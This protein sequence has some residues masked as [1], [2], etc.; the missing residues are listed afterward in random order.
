MSDSVVRTS[1]PSESSS[2]PEPN[3]D[4]QDVSLAEE[5][6]LLATYQEKN[7]LPYT[8]EY[9][10][11]GDV[12]DRDKSLSDD[13][14]D[15]ESYLRDQVTK[16]ELKNSVDAGKKRLKELEKKADVDPVMD[17]ENTRIRKLTAYIDFLRTIS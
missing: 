1:A 14:K 6:S 9:F 7:G 3:A 16:E 5:K 12:W 15:I 13:L 10:E 17:T 11:L 8:A 4:R 2:L